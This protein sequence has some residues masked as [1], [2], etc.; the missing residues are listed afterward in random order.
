MENQ[1]AKEF[2]ID[3]LSKSLI[4]IAT[5]E[6]KTKKWSQNNLA[7]RLSELAKSGL[8]QGSYRKGKSFKEWK[9]IQMVSV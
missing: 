8:I 1:T 4:P 9:L 5:H 6:F 2:I 7:T 3:E